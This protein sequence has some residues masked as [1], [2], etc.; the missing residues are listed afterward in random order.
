MHSPPSK[1]LL[2]TWR[3]PV[4]YPQSLLWGNLLSVWQTRQKAR[5]S[6]GGAICSP[7]AN[8]GIH[9]KGERNIGFTPWVGRESV[10]EGDSKLGAK[11]QEVNQVKK[12]GWGRKKKFKRREQHMLRAQSSER[13]WGL[14]EEITSWIGSECECT[15][16]VYPFQVH[17][18]RFEHYKRT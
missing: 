5:N 10:G 16:C 12:G 11:M 7:L 8:P 2:R 17:Y 15:R 14:R 13:A 4:S 9:G 3:E 18:E 1:T 6:Q